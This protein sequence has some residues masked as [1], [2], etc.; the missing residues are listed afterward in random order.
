MPQ[1]WS[2]YTQ[3]R[4]L[5]YPALSPLAVRFN[6]RQSLL[7]LSGLFFF[8]Q[9]VNLALMVTHPNPSMRIYLFKVVSGPLAVKRIFLD[10]GFCAVHLF[11]IVARGGLEV[12]RDRALIGVNF[13][14]HA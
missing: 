9:I 7:F 6:G 3:K 5:E 13:T 11:K 10:R 4:A 12:K 8:T 2:P 1:G 14:N